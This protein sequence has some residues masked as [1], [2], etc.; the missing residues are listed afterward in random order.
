[1]CANAA[2]FF[3]TTFLIS[4]KATNTMCMDSTGSSVSSIHLQNL[5][6]LT[7]SFLKLHRLVARCWQ[8]QTAVMF[9]VSWV[10]LFDGKSR[11]SSIIYL[12]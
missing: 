9:S 3:T 1:M 2:V 12:K 7:D 4:F 11:S 8:L 6:Q 10:I 5:E